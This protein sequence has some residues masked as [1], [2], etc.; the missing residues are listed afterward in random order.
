MRTNLYCQA[1][2]PVSKTPS[3]HRCP[4]VIRFVKT[5]GALFIRLECA[6]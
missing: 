6:P 1:P 3:L 2:S 5:R 4:S